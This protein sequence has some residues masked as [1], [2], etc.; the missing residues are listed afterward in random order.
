M[1]FGAFFHA[2]SKITDAVEGANKYEKLMEQYRTDRDSMSS[3]E[4]HYLYGS[5][6]FRSRKDKNDAGLAKLAE[7]IWKLKEKKYYAEE[8]AR[9]RGA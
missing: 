9:N 5:V 4:L 1:G 2:L 6:S 8:F 7:E 3:E